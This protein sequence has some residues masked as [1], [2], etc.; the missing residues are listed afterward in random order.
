[1]MMMTEHDV[2]LLI[3]MLLLLNYKIKHNKCKTRTVKKLKMINQ[4]IQIT[5]KLKK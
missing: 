5:I 4:M 3:T 1:M 2:V